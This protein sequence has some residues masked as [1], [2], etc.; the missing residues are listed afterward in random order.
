MELIK[1][2]AV[3]GHMPVLF[4]LNKDGY[5]SEEDVPEYMTINDPRCI[6]AELWFVAGEQYVFIDREPGAEWSY[7]AELGEIEIFSPGEKEVHEYRAFCEPEDLVPMAR[8]YAARGA[9]V[10]PVLREM[11]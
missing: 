1:K 5:A 9:Q 11:L 8:R 6:R 10:H 3:E 7:E 4:A 2:L